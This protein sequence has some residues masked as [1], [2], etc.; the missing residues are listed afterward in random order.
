M[1]IRDSPKSIAYFRPLVKRFKQRKAARKQF[2]LLRTAPYPSLKL[3]RFQRVALVRAVCNAAGD[4]HRRFRLQCERVTLKC[5]DH[6][7]AA[8]GF[9]TAN[10]ELK[11]L[12]TAPAT[13]SAVGTAAERKAREVALKADFR[14]KFAVILLENEICFFGRK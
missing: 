4:C 13:H 14:R 5:E 3:F 12:V 8:C 10:F 9:R 1:C 7:S 2:F 6:S 11:A